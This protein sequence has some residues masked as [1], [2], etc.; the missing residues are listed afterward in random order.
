[1]TMDGPDE[2][3]IVV[4]EP[5][6]AVVDQL[7]DEITEFNFAATGIRDGRE[8][9]AAVHDARG[10]LVGG[11]YGWTWG[12]TGWIEYL[13]VREDARHAGL[14]SRLLDAAADEARRRGCRQLALSTHSFQAPDFYRRHGFEVVGEIADYPATHSS[15]AMRRRL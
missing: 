2:Q 6:R 7:R 5:D 8:L 1:M 3:L 15:L 11:V 9:F 10:A 12:G 14:G 13:W 4:E